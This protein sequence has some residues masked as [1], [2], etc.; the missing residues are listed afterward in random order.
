MCCESDPSNMPVNESVVVSVPDTEQLIEV[1]SD[2]D[3][4]QTDV[5]LATSSSP[6]A[7]P[8]NSTRFLTQS[9]S[10]PAQSHFASWMLKACTLCDVQKSS[11]NIRILTSYVL[12]FKVDHNNPYI[13]H[14]TSPRSCLVHIESGT[15]KNFEKPQSISNLKWLVICGFY[16]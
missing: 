6:L 14:R 13:Y 12:H 4:V 10:C 15:E 16:R 1:D 3:D 11:G 8:N 5:Q 9:C 2:G 7:I